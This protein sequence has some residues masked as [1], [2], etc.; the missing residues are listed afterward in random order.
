MTALVV[1]AVLAVVAALFVLAPLARRSTAPRDGYPGG[2]GAGTTPPAGAPA[3][4]PQP[5]A[6]G[7]A[8]RPTARGGDT[9]ERAALEELELDR[10]MGKLGEQDYQ[11]LRAQVVAA[12]TREGTDTMSGGTNPA[13]SPVRE[14]LE[15]EAEAVITAQRTATRRCGACGDRPEPAAAFCSSCGRP[16]E[17]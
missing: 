5:R 11:R 1:I 4:P 17:G 9:T 8:R 3:T 2:P 12:A 13:A 15:E 10:A 7:A 6:T 14:P 16:I